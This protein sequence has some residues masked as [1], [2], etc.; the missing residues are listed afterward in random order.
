MPSYLIFWV[1]LGAVM[2]TKVCIE[3]FISNE[4]QSRSREIIKELDELILKVESRRFWPTHRRIR[5]ID[6]MSGQSFRA[7]LNLLF[8]KASKTYLEIGV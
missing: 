2:R 1:S 7:L 8:S 5:F 4:M 6:G 3:R